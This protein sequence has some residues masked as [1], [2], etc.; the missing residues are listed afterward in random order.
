[1]QAYAP[2]FAQLG[3]AYILL[4]ADNYGT[5]PVDLAREKSKL[6]LDRALQL[7]PE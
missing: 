1:M 2:A 5:L 6:N 4:G 3:I 7:E